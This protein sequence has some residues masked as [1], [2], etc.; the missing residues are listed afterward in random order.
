M[1]LKLKLQSALQVEGVRSSE[2]RASS[3]FQNGRKEVLIGETEGGPRSPR[4]ST[5]SA[6][7]DEQ[8]EPILR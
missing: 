3:P 2:R 5:S 8:D 6:V 7:N 1:N 4:G